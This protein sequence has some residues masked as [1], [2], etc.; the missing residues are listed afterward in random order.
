MTLGQ[1]T[2]TKKR[3]SR[4]KE[5]INVITCLRDEIKKNITNMNVV[6][7]STVTLGDISTVSL[8]TFMK[9]L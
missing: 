4:A 8:L 9:T 7:Y 2:I 1:Y 6:K 5:A 3:M